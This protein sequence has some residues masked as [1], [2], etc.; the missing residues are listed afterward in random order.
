VSAL[1]GQVEPFRQSG[2]AVEVAHLDTRNKVSPL[3]RGERINGTCRAIRIS[4][5]DKFAL[6]RNPDARAA[7]ACA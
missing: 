6:T 5:Q 4:D 3:V 2:D 7:L 1:A